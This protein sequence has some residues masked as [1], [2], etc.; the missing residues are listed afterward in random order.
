M[1]TD[2]AVNLFARIIV[3]SA[4]SLNPD[5]DNIILKRIKQSKVASCSAPDIFSLTSFAI[6]NIFLSVSYL[7]QWKAYVLACIRSVD[8]LNSG[9]SSVGW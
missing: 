3:D 7:Y 4:F 9:I 2:F 1:P 6:S 8:Q 5:A